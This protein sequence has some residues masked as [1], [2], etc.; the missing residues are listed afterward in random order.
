MF[1]RYLLAKVYFTKFN[2]CTYLNLII[3][4]CQKIHF[5]NYIKHIIDNSKNKYNLIQ[6]ILFYNIKII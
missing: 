2:G 4:V 1:E 6:V 5:I 3:C